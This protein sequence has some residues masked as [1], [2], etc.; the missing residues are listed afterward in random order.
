[1]GLRMNLKADMLEGP[2]VRARARVEA[3]FFDVGWGS[4]IVP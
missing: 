1:M 4:R 2:V 3:E